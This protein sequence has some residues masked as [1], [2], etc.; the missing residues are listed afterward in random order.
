MA[1]RRKAPSKPAAG[2]EAANRLTPK[3]EAFAHA[4]VRLRDARAAYRE[5]GY[6]PKANDKTAYDEGLRLA[7][8][9]GVAARIRELQAQAADAASVSLVG[10]LHEL[11]VLRDAAVRRHQYAAAITAEVARGKAAGVHVE[12]TVQD[13][14]HHHDDDDARAAALADR[15]E[16]LQP[17][18][19]RH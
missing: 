4:L 19:T 5:A 1:T 3:Q 12:R 9:P 16:R 14:T 8:S 18:A 7:Q 11:A 17:E 10:H 2:S 15:L 13:V 6:G